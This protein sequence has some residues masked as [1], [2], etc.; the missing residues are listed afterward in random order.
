MSSRRIGNY[1]IVDYIGSGGFGSVF[2]AEDVNT[3]GRIVAIKELHKKHTRNSSIKQRFFQEAIAMARLDHPNLPRLYTFGEDNGSYYLV[4]EFLSGKPLSDQI[5]QDGAIEQSRALNMLAQVLEGVSYAHRNSIIHR[6]LKP[7]NVFLMNGGDG[8]RI[9]VLDFGIARIV[10]G[11]NLT[12]TGESFGTPNY[13]SPERITGSQAIDHRTDIYALGIMLFEMLTGRAPFQSTATDPSLY[14]SEMRTR[15]ESEPLPPMGGSE[16]IEMIARRATA[17]RV[18]DRYPTADEMLADLRKVQSPGAVT[19]SEASARLSVVTAPCGAEV[20]VD[21]ISRGVS[22][23]PGGRISIDRLAPGLHSVRV[24]KTGYSDYKIS[25][26]LEED[27]QTD[28][29]VA[30]AARATMAMP[31][32]DLTGPVDLNT[33]KIESGDEAK[34]AL[35]VVDDLPEGTTIFVGSKAV[36]QAGDD[37]RATIKLD[38]GVHEI[39]AT[40]P[41]GVGAKRMVT[42]SSEDGGSLM[43]IKMPLEPA[44]V[45]TSPMT[46]DVQ[47]THRSG[48]RLAAVAAI[49]ILLMLVAG[50]F[51]VLRGPERGEARVVEP[52]DPTA[53]RERSILEAEQAA[54]LHEQAAEAQRK[55]AEE[56]EAEKRAAEKETQDPKVQNQ[57]A[58]N[59]AAPQPAAA[60]ATQPAPPRQLPAQSDACLDVLVLNPRGEPMPR[61]RVAVFSSGNS[62]GGMT[63]MN[64]KWG[65]CGL[66]AGQAVRIEVTGMRMGA[67]GMRQGVVGPGRNEFVIRAKRNLQ[68]M[69]LDSQQELPQDKPRRPG[70]FRRP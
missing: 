24:S 66:T 27:R 32:V 10:G 3:P 51:F 14:W 68:M 64:G 30:L 36:A 42:V 31:Q 67:I 45:V 56:V 43:T 60:P 39:Q 61:M 41:S 58:Q 33:E 25:V 54:K 21:N 20:F 22:G 53:E 12:L 6:D 50:A 26:S 4:M 62:V 9:K 52:V 63:D 15:H 1:Q 40:A 16:A 44:A 29:Q 57:T 49:A 46:S 23:D 59:Q 35:F 47:Q 17:K 28:L 70:R 48:K 18:E 7:D 19:A 38:P 8:L 69:P 11:E 55:A 37:G 34:T 2:K 5:Q 65:R 13:M